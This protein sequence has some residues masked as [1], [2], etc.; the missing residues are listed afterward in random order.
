MG[1]TFG[2]CLAMLTRSRPERCENSTAYTAPSVRAR[3]C[4]YVSETAEGGRR[5][6]FLT[7][8]DHL[9]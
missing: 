1:M 6:Q 8:V 3:V 9:P 7:P 5:K 4:V 2:R